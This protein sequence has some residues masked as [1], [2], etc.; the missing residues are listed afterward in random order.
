LYIWQLALKLYIIWSQERL[1]LSQV[2]VCSVQVNLTDEGSGDTAMAVL[3]GFGHTPLSKAWSYLNHE[4]TQN[5]YETILIKGRVKYL[6]DILVSERNCW[7][8]H[9]YFMKGLQETTLKGKKCKTRLCKRKLKV[10]DRALREG[11]YLYGR[12]WSVECCC[13]LV[14]HNM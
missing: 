4:L 7:S 9:K 12:K 11:R 2:G 14:C 13:P 5:L 6:K 3:R 1:S 8:Q 10:D